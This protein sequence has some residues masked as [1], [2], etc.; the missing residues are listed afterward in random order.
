MS[1]PLLLVVGALVILAVVL[2]VYKVVKAA[3]VLGLAA[4]LVYVV[5]QYAFPLWER[6]IAPFVASA[7]SLF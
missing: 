3:V 2:A 6:H 1:T 7:G 4:V 5:V